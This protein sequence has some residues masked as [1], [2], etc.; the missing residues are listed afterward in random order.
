MISNDLPYSQAF[1]G[2]PIERDPGMWERA[3]PMAKAAREAAEAKAAEAAAAAAAANAE[4]GGGEGGGGGGSAQGGG[5]GGSS[6]GVA[7]A[8]SGAGGG[9]ASG[10]MPAP[11][12]PLTVEELRAVV[13]AH[14]T[15]VMWMMGQVIASCGF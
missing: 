9:A 13:A 10:Q 4:G 1:V 7:S 12:D 6:S 14:Y 3:Q 8:T 2:C 11:S 5:E 15:D